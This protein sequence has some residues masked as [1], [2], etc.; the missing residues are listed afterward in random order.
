MTRCIV[1]FLF[2]NECVRIYLVVEVLQCLP[3]FK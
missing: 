2:F 1:N 3:H